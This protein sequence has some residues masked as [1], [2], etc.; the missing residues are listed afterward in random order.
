MLALRKPSPLGLDWISHQPF[1][2]TAVVT[3][4]RRSSEVAHL[5]QSL[6]L[7]QRD[8]HLSNDLEE[9]RRADFAPSVERYGHRAAVW[10]VPAFVTTCLSCLGEPQRASRLL[11][12]SRRGA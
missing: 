1:S 7:F 12:V 9:K 11:E 8:S 2:E 3:K 10:M 5:S 4:A 6:K